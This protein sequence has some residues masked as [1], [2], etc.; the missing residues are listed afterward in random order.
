MANTW[1][2]TSTPRSEST[3][4]R[5]HPC[6]SRPSHLPPAPPSRLVRT[7]RPSTLSALPTEV[8]TVSGLCRTTTARPGLC[9]RP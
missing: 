5:T 7:S 8:D 6:A 9:S 3:T 1:T 4:A 2:M